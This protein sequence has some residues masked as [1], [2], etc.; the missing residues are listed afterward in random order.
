MYLRTS[1]ALTTSVTWQYPS[2][3]A[4]AT[5][6]A[7]ARRSSTRS[8]NE[9]LKTRRAPA[10]QAAVHMYLRTR[11]SRRSSVAAAAWVYRY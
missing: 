7:T 8:A 11:R 10:L 2:A 3:T 1:V 5:S 9:R 6:L 4:L